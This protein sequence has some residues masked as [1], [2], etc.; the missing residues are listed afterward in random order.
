M[1]ELS[2]PDIDTIKRWLQRAGIEHYICDHCHGLHLPDIQAVEGVLES[3]LF[4]EDWGLLLST[5]YLIRPSALLP[6]V[7]EL[8]HLNVDFPVLKL[9]SDVVDDAL[10]QLVAGAS[11]LTGAG[12]GENQFA[13]FLATVREALVGLSGEL[14]QMDVLMP[15]EQI[16]A[17]APGRVH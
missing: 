12:L 3:R 16:P 7:A 5:E 9:F 1:T 2:L 8:G 15:P 13:L 6:L 4:V 17:A 11:L 14:Q 10:P